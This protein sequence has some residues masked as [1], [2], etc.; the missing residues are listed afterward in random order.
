MFKMLRQDVSLEL[1]PVKVPGQLNKAT[2][3]LYL[4]PVVL[5]FW[6]AFIF[7]F[8]YDF[9]DKLANQVVQN[10][11][12]YYGDLLTKLPSDFQNFWYFLLFI[13]AS[14][15]PGS[16]VLKFLKL[17]WRDVVE[18]T[19][20][21]IAFGL[22]IFT[23]VTLALGSAGF[24]WRNFFLALLGLSLVSSF[25]YGL[26]ICQRWLG[27]RRLYREIGKLEPL[28]IRFSWRLAL[29][30]GL[31]VW[32]IV[33]AYLTLLGGL[34][35]EVQ[36]DARHYHLGPPKQY[37]QR[38]SIYDIV[39]DSSMGEASFTPY[40]EM[41]YTQLTVSFNLITAKLLHW[42]DGILAALLLIYFCRVYFKSLAIGLVA[43]IGFISIPVVTWSTST[44]NNDLPGAFYGLLSLCAFL[45][46]KE[47]PENS[48]WLIV[49][50]AL[51]GYS[52]GIKPFG[53]FG[54]P[55]LLLGIVIF[56]Y[57]TARRQNQVFPW[58]RV[59]L[60]I[61]LVGLTIFAMCVP[62]FIRAYATTG[63]PIFPFLN[64]VFKSPY[65]NQ[66]S[67]VLVQKANLA[68]GTD[69]SL[70]GFVKLPWATIVEAN[71]YRGILSPLFLLALPLCVVASIMLRQRI[72]TLY[73]LL[74]LYLMVWLVLWFLSGAVE[75]RYILPVLP[76][77]LVLVAYVVIKPLWQGWSA[78]LL[79]VSLLIMFFS[80]TI[81]NSALLVPFVK[82]AT[83][84]GMFGRAI[85]PWEFFY[86]NGPEENVQLVYAPMIQYIN[87]NLSPVTD[88]VYD[89]DTVYYFM[90]YSD[91]RI[92]TGRH[93][94]SPTVLQQW[95]ID[96]PDVMQHFK[97][98]GITHVTVF[99]RDA[100]RI[101][102][103]PVG[104]YLSK[105]YQVRSDG[106]VL[107]KVNYPANM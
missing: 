5:F 58:A 96:S 36:Y 57:Q 72:G 32:L 101:M 90:V 50:A 6:F 87:K 70:W 31:V 40:Q 68:N 28:R 12:K 23:F 46:W 52:T 75:T 76:I 47:Q 106:E 66:Y 44:A 21:S 81:F 51:I 1:K 15:G 98:A 71:K 35:P 64:G 60:Q 2:Y 80:I 16:L 24:L 55:L 65:W 49:M 102:Q 45:R 26:R 30:V 17:N 9:S 22:V 104:K 99:S 14:I 100:Q 20:F 43:A 41:L 10:S 86:R 88:K 97:E 89:L 3:L 82:Y 29:M 85:I 37:V 4:V 8:S 27:R 59:S 62:W 19:F 63:N 11:S 103:L 94:S 25:W 39:K 95:S 84:P 105:L 54:L 77:A 107:F 7:I 92:F 67:D 18:Q 34:S 48:R 73:R 93:L 91:I 61:V 83:T 53:A 79:Q 74:T 42:G 69:R 38:G 78:R 56:S 13:V 33:Y